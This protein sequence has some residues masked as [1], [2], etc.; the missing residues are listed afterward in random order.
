MTLTKEKKEI[1][2]SAL[3]Q[4]IMKNTEEREIMNELFDEIDKEIEV[5]D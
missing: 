5:L 1:L 4:L 2:L 3:A